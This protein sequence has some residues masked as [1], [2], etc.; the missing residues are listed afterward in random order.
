MKGEVMKR[1]LYFGTI[2][3]FLFVFSS[4]IHTATAKTLYDDFPEDYIDY[5]K[6]GEI[7][8]VREVNQGELLMNYPAAELRGIIAMRSLQIISADRGKFVYRLFLG[9]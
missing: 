6:W 3:C 7:D 5:S 4:M 2:L 1:F 9:P 8:F